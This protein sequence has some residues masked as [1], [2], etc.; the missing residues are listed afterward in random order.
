[1][2][3]KPFKCQN[4]EP[5][6]QNLNY[7]LDNHVFEK[8]VTELDNMSQVKIKFLILCFDLECTKRDIR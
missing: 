8:L 4:V 6:S 2:E 1:M 7:P 3:L 5:K